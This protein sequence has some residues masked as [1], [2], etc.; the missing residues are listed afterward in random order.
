MLCDGIV[1]GNRDDDLDEQG[2]VWGWRSGVWGRG[3]VS[4]SLIC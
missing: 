4:G 2:W 3:L 1:F